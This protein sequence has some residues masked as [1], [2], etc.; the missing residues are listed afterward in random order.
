MKGSLEEDEY[1]EVLNTILSVSRGG[2]DK[3][4]ASRWLSG[5]PISQQ[6]AKRIANIIGR[7]WIDIYS[8]QPAAREGPKRKRGHG[9]PREDLTS[10]G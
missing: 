2:I 10:G 6:T 8:L 7:Q 5:K 9:R 4:L 1:K 3:A